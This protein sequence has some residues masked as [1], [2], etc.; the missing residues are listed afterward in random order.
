MI[1]LLLK[2]PAEPA[3]TQEATS[4]IQPTHKARFIRR[5]HALIV[6]PRLEIQL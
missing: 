2:A 6:R 4:Q 3:S 1:R 5:I